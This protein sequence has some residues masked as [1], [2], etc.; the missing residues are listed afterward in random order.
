MNA[1]R[2]TL[3]AVFAHPD[4]ESFGP[5]GTLARYAAEGVAV[6]LVC[7][8]RGEAGE[9]DPSLLE[10]YESLAQRRTAELE[11]AARVLGLAG[12]YFLGYRDSGMVGTADNSHPNALVNAPVAEVAEKVTAYIRRL[13]P[14]V[15][16][17][18]DPHGGYGHLDHIAIHRATVAAFHA[19]GDP[20]AYP[21]QFAAG[22][23]PWSP[24]KLY[25]TTF[26][27]RWLRFLVRI[28]PLF[29]VDP[30]AL[31]EN[32]DI[33]LKEIAE[34]QQPVTTWIDVRA[35]LE[36]KQRAG[37]CHST[38]AG[39]SSMLSRLP[40]WLVRW[41][42]GTETFYRAYPEGATRETDL[43]AGVS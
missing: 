14:Q 7:A 20:T 37:A 42:M 36:V 22:L 30:T 6:H 15:V 23:T 4:D 1:H 31:G 38:Q 43:F 26:N 24:Q 25:Y 35:Y 39:P 41:V 19:A 16:I 11:C 27:R 32:R 13:Q 21:E 33:N 40:G 12:V 34:I 17:T 10:G 9:A 3:L 2:R 5:G 29:R 8:T 18:S 28:L